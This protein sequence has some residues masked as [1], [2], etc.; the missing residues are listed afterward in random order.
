[1]LRVAHALTLDHSAP[2]SLVNR[3]ELLQPLEEDILPSFTMENTSEK[4]QQVG[5]VGFALRAGRIHIYVV[6]AL[7]AAEHLVCTQN[8]LPRHRA[9]PVEEHGLVEANLAG[10]KVHGR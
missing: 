7:H 4:H 3:S 10:M 6:A 5:N 2:R 9:G 8:D 1:M